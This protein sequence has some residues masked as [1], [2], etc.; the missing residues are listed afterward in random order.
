MLLGKR[1]N[2][3]FFPRRTDY[4]SAVSKS[5]N[6]NSHP[7][8]NPQNLTCD[9]FSESW[10]FSSKTI[11]YQYYDSEMVFTLGERVKKLLSF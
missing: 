6:F 7:K 9:I 4:V 8:K 5:L 2:S 10:F 1:C 3:V 11:I